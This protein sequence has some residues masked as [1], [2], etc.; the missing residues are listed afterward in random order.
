MKSR[1]KSKLF[2]LFCLAV[3]MILMK[4]AYDLNNRILETSSQSKAYVAI[5]IDDFGYG[6]AGTKEMLSL[7]IPFTAAVMPFL[8]SSKQDSK[9]AVEAGKEVIIHMPMESYT[10]KK[11]WLGPRSINAELTDDEVKKLVNDAMEEIEG[12]VG[13][14][15]HMGSKVTE[16]NRLMKDIL[17]IVKENNMVFIDSMT[18]ANS[19]TKSVSEE[20]GTISLYRDV[21]LDSTTEQE[22]VEQNL[23]E[24]ADKALQKGYAVGIGHVGPEGG[25]ITAAAIKK[26]APE[27]KE[28][29]IEF[30]T[31]TELRDIMKD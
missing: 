11:A 4:Q 8:E 15:N 28:R 21:F 31:I 24:L 29:G 30:V 27:L 12:A 7:D 2:L 20:I 10:G 1:I 18:T 19:V 6:G 9:A 26:L 22:K 23:I 13:I 14:N 3:T 17:E 25:K 5:I 16:D